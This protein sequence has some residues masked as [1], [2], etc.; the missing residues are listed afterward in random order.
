MY[1]RMI[2]PPRRTRLKPDHDLGGSRTISSPSMIGPSLSTFERRL[3]L[4]EPYSKKRRTLRRGRWYSNPVF[5]ALKHP[6]PVVREVSN[7]LIGFRLLESA[8]D[9]SRPTKRCRLSHS[10]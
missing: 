10:S 6:S 5:T 3:V 9:L 4:M 2:C 7:D 1:C 8:L